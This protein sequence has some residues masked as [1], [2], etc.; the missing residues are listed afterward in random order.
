MQ[1]SNGAVSVRQTSNG[2]AVSKEAGIRAAIYLRQSIDRYGNEIAVT[3]QREDCV[4]LCDQRGWK[5]LPEYLDNDRSASNGKPRPSYLR[6]I[7]DIEDDKVDAVVAW[8]ADRLHRRPM[9][10]E[11]F[12]DLA[13]RKRLALATVGGDFDLSSPTGRGNARMKGVFARM[14][15]EQKSFRQKRALLQKAQRGRPF[16]KVAFGYLPDTR[17]PEH[18]D[19]TRQLDPATAPLVKEAYDHMRSGGRLVDIVNRWNAAG[20]YGGRSVR[21][22]DAD[23]HIIKTAEVEWTTKKWSVPRMHAFLREARNAALCKYNGEGD[24]SDLREGV[25]GELLDQDGEPIRGLWPPLVDEATW[26]DVQGILRDNPHHGPPTVRKHL[27]TGV[28]FCGLCEGPLGAGWAEP[29]RRKTAAA[30]GSANITAKVAPLTTKLVGVERVPTRDERIVALHGQGKP[31][32]RIATEIGC[33]RKTVALVLKKHAAGEPL[34]TP[35]TRYIRYMCASRDCRGCSIREDCIVPLVEKLVGERLA[36]EDAVDL[37]KAEM[38]DPAEAEAL[39]KE[40][41]Q[42]LDDLDQLAVDRAQHLL[43]SRQVKISTDIILEKLAVIERQQQDED[44]V[45]VFEGLSLGTADVITEIKQLAT[46]SPGRFRAIIDMLVRV[47]IM[48]AGKGVRTFNPERVQV[49][50]K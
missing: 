37:L 5:I 12:I 31:K 23:G 25:Y 46:D 1:S 2:A 14:E 43:T 34:R 11:A 18:D 17:R 38:R 6:L 33:D 22:R 35:P 10:L 41:K 20:L 7:I 28:I 40:A 47:R 42:L 21:P 15:M 26:R 29:Y 39:R 19:G 24:K 4:R 32:T 27:L 44:R 13:D 9:E 8:D 48:P 36:R 45:R 30:G 49:E 16:W 3:R 50:W